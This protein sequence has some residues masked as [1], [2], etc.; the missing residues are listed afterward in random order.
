MTFAA[1]ILRRLLLFHT[2]PLYY[3]DS[4]CACVY[5]FRSV[6]VARKKRIKVPSSAAVNREPFASH[7]ETSNSF[8]APSSLPFFLPFL[9]IWERPNNNKY[10]QRGA[11]ARN[12]ALAFFPFSS[13][14]ISRAHTH[15]HTSTR[16]SYATSVPS[17]QLSCAALILKFRHGGGR[18][19]VE[20]SVWM[21]NNGNLIH[22]SLPHKFSTVSQS[23]ERRGRRR[24]DFTL[25]AVTSPA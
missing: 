1:R 11:A 18:S 21:R 3:P 22:M 17:T 14:F 15:I 9:S 2:V 19:L 23:R 8:L 12:A 25:L 16:N 6:F 13:F 24:R 10:N 20:F 5:D 4:G 7:S